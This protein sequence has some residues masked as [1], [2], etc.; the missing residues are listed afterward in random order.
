MKKKKLFIFSDFDGVF[1]S[2]A[3]WGNSTEIAKKHFEI[4][5]LDMNRLNFVDRICRRLDKNTEVWFISISSWKEQYNQHLKEVKKLA[6][7]KRMKLICDE[8]APVRRF[9]ERE[10]WCR[11]NLIKY[12]LDAYSP[13]NF[14][15]LDD[16]FQY[17][18]KNHG[19][20]EQL[21]V[22]DQYDGLT[23]NTMKELQKKIEAC[24]LSKEVIDAEKHRQEVISMLAGCA[25]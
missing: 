25:V 14:I 2:F 18:Y 16:E 4:K 1:A 19:Y 10:P 8:N 17:E 13:E 23:Y 3:T 22:T 7:I 11:L 5:D 6:G 24:G 21:I 9:S 20:E 12:Y 15:I